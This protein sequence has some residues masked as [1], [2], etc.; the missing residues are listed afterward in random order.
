MRFESV[1][2]IASYSHQLTYLSRCDWSNVTVSEF[3]CN[4]SVKKYYYPF[5]QKTKVKTYPME[6]IDWIDQNM[7]NQYLSI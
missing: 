2:T 3:K 5:V 4:L 1:M 6:V 7:H